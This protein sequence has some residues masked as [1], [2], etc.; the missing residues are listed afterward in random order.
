MTKIRKAQNKDFK[1]I[2]KIFR[3]EYGKP[4]Y[5]EKWSE[6]WATKKVREYY[7]ENFIF[8]MELEKKIGGFII[9]NFYTWDD[10]I[11]GFVNELVVSSKFQGKGYGTR[12]FR[13]FENFIKKKGSKKISLLSSTKSRAFKLYKKLGFKREDL[14]SMVKKLK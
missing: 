1:Q 10:G 9:G 14:V 5:N 6:K 4:P 2:V 7:N 12:L 13:H 11:R 8:V 3:T